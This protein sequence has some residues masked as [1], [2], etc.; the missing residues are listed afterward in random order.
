[1]VV[2]TENAVWIQNESW[3]H[4]NPNI[5]DTDL[6]GVCDTLAANH[7]KYAFIYVGGWAQPATIQYVRTDS[8]FQNVVNRLHAHGILAIAWVMAYSVP[9]DI[10]E[11]NQSN[12]YDAILDCMDRV[13][14]DGYNDDI[15][16]FTGT[17]TEWIDYINGLTPIL[18]NIGKLNMPDVPM[19]WEQNINQYLIVDYIVSMFYNGGSTLEH[20]W[21]NLFWQ[22]NFGEYGAYAPPNEH[23]PGSPIIVG[24][25]TDYGYGNQYPLAWL[26]GKAGEFYDAYGHPQLA[27]FSLWLYEYVGLAQDDWQQWHYWID[28][29]GTTTPP[30]FTINI[31]AAP[32]SVKMS[33]DDVEEYTPQDTWGFT[34][35]RTIVMPEES[36]AAGHSVSF[37][38]SNHLGNGMAFSV[39][40]YASGPYTLGGSGDTINGVY[41]YTPVSGHVKV[42]IYSSDNYHITGWI[43]TDEHPDALLCQSAATAV[44]AE[45][46]NLITLPET[47][48][49][50]GIYFI[51]IKVD[52]NYLLKQSAVLPPEYGHDQYITQDYATAFSNPFPQPEGQMG[53]DAAAYIPTALIVYTTYYFNKWEDNTTNRTRV[54]VV[55]SNDNLVATY[56]LAPGGGGDVPSWPFMGYPYRYLSPH[57]RLWL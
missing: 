6:E 25:R 4:H 10:T 47:N 32:T 46:W 45:T 28:R 31:A 19:D 22:E 30:L 39:Y 49:A 21:N 11:A 37:G 20:L 40:C 8:Y 44:V 41:V 7:I 38:E 1:M 3:P 36:E 42:A 24:I 15:E 5:L 55:D 2:Y 50:A 52:T 26:L 43:G 51:V 34:G 35:S 53:Y 13:S 57:S 9:I 56:I 27:G 12:I 18:T 16:Y 17:R 14:W 33:I 29:I 48:L 54:V 23:P